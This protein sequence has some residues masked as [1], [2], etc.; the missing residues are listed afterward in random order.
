MVADRQKLGTFLGVFTPTVLTILGVILYLRTGWVVGQVGLLE[1][2]AIVVIANVITLVTTLS[3]SS[4]ATNMKVRGGGA[5]YI[6]SRSLGL[7]VGAAVGIPLYLSQ[8]VSVTLYA[9][10][11]AESLRIVWPEVDL[12]V[13]TIIIILAVALISLRGAGV[14]LKAQLPLLIVVGLSL[15]ALVIGVLVGN[16]VEPMLPAPP[17]EPPSFWLVFAVFFPAVTGIMAGLSLSGDLKEPS[18]SIPIGAIS[19]MLVGFVIYLA[20]PWLLSQ[21]V[22]AYALVT[23]PLIWTSIA[24]GGFWLI[25]PGLWGAILSSAVGSILGAPRT[26]QAVLQ[27]QLGQT[28]LARLVASPWGL[29]TLLL[30]STAV[31]VGAVWLGALDTVATV[32]TVFFLTVYGTVNFAAGIERLSGDPSWRPRLRV[33]WWLNIACGVGCLAVIFLISPLAGLI[34]LLVEFLLWLTFSRR[35]SNATWGDARRGLY[36]SLFRWALI[37][38]ARRPM[39][40]RNWRPH[41][42]VFVDDPERRIDLVRFASWFSQNRGVVSVCELVRG[43]LL[44]ESVDLRERELQMQKLIDRERLTAFP[45]AFTVDS[46]DSGILGVAQA[47]GMAGMTSNLVMLG[48]PKEDDMFVRFLD[49]T[50]RLEKLNKSV[51]IGKI[52]PSHRGRRGGAIVHVWWGG[53]KQNG[54]LMVLLAYLLT[55]NPEWRRSTLKILSAASNAF[56]RDNTDRYLRSLIADVRMDAEC[57]VFLKP[58]SQSVPELIRSRSSMADAVFLGLAMPVAGEEQAYVSRLRDLVGELP[59]VFLVKNSSVFVG[60]LLATDDDSQVTGTPQTTRV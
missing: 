2:L 27:D 45:Q 31:A 58:E 38:L 40:A 37:R 26:L 54:D 25:L 15:A 24:I 16:R 52:D 6:I 34:A 55:R 19:A 49:T 43:D 28:R 12:T 60:D 57:E 18:R 8:T 42:L 10:G 3:F 47:T 36:E 53:L 17:L 56:A 9:F 11:L 23:Q 20:I 59:S 14:A 13:V 41:V 1:T 30:L 5:Y 22:P 7:A 51:V 46:I 39:S 29:N 35:E 50:R 32:V 4:M 21:A 33:P 44:T 48:W